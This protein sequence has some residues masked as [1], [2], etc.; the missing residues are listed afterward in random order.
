MRGR[1]QFRH[2]IKKLLPNDKRLDTKEI[3]TLFDALD[4]DKGGEL[5]S[6]ELRLALKKLQVRQ[7]VR[8]SGR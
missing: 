8:S 6:A 7:P 1:P 2:N 5:D 4:E 3:D